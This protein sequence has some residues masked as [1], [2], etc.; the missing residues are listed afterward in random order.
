MIGQ[1]PDEDLGVRG[2]LLRR[3]HLPPGPARR[4]ALCTH[5][6]PL[7]RAG[8]ARR[9]P[10]PKSALLP[11][12]LLGSFFPLLSAQP[13]S[14]PQFPPSPPPS[15]N[16]IPFCLCKPSFLL[17]ERSP[18]ASGGSEVGTGKRR[19]GGR[20]AASLPAAALKTADAAA[21]R[22]APALGANNGVA[23]PLL[24]AT[25]SGTGGCSSSS[26]GRGRRRG[27]P[28]ARP[29]QRRG[30]HTAAGNSWVPPCPVRR[31]PVLGAARQKVCSRRAWRGA[32]CPLMRISPGF[33]HTERDGRLRVLRDHHGAG[34]QRA[35]PKCFSPSPK[36]C[37]ETSAT[38]TYLSSQASKA[39]VPQHL[40]YYCRSGDG[41]CGSC[42]CW[43]WER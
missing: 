14:P 6:W 33:V 29:R 40:H 43:D 2:V 7:G 24:K 3:V 35:V 13:P 8:P 19:R 20:A 21:G 22:E 31:E 32:R 28:R 37:G 39:V 1:A 15:Y 17:Q 30:W 27:G 16:A 42:C 34:K 25:G 38:L 11:R 9:D 10:L 26:Q 4:A 18:A 36:A 5:A 41:D 23:S 12:S